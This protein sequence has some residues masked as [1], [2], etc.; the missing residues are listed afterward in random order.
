MRCKKEKKCDAVPNYI[1]TRLKEGN[2]YT[3]CEKHRRLLIKRNDLL[4]NLQK[5][6]K[7][8]TLIAV[9]NFSTESKLQFHEHQLIFFST[10]LCNINNKDSKINNFVCV[11]VLTEIWV[12]NEKKKLT[13]CSRCHEGR[14]VV[15]AH[16]FS[17]WLRLYWKCRCWCCNNFFLIINKHSSLL[18]IYVSTLCLFFLP[19]D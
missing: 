8:M 7:K 5:I 18:M 4:R 16:I 9:I 2:D 19:L 3:N 6:N 10:K 14:F 12:E 15:L 11:L 1:I 17:V 13:I